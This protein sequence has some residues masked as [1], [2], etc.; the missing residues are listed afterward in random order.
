MALASGA[1]WPS[2]SH[3]SWPQPRQTRALPSDVEFEPRIL[4]LI[5]PSHYFPPFGKQ[6]S[7]QTRP[8]DNDIK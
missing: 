4:A 8:P 6:S 5:A 3:A 7:S 1:G 2:P